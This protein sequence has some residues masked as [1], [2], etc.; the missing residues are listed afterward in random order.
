[1]ADEED[2][3]R[4]ERARAI[5]LFRYQLIREAADPAHSTRE[6]GRLVR[7]IA[8]AEH[9]DPFGRRVRISRQ[10]VDRAADEA[11]FML[12]EA[13]RAVIARQLAGQQ[14]ILR[15]LE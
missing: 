3:K 12:L 15:E 1:M 9:V 5:G 11:V 6:R 7:R 2:S 8:A 13:G 10:T 4:I 14:S